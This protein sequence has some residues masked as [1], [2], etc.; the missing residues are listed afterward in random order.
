MPYP[1]FVY[2]W[3]F[4]SSSDSYLDKD[5]FVVSQVLKSNKTHKSVPI[6]L[7]DSPST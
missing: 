2:T 4:H 1:S 3:A 5:P 6:V 7:S